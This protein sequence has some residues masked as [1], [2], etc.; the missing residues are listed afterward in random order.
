M[1]NPSPVSGTASSHSPSGSHENL[2]EQMP[3]AF[4][5]ADPAFALS[6]TLL[7]RLFRSVNRNLSLRLWNGTIVKVGLGVGQQ[8]SSTFELVFH[9]PLV[10]RSM[11][12]GRDPLRIAEAYFRGDMDIE[13]DFFAAVGLK[14]DLQSIRMSLY[15]RL[16]TLYGALQ[17]KALARG[18]PAP[19]VPP[20]TRLRAVTAHSK[21]ENRAAI[22]F[23]YDVSNDF[24][25]LWLDKNMVYS[26]AYFEALDI[27]LDQAQEAK[28][29]YVCRKLQLQPTDQLLDIGCGWGALII[30]AAKHYGVRA[31]GITL[32][33][34]QL[35]RGRE[36]IAEAGLENRV[37]IDLQDYRELEGTSVYEKISSVGMVEHV[38]LKNL[39]RYFSTVQRLLKPGGLFLN[40]G[41]TSDS[42]G[43]EK[44]LSTE[45][46]NRYVFPDGQLDTISNIQ[47]YM[48]QA[49]FEIADVESL[50]AHYALTLRHWVKRLE[51]NHTEALR[52]VN[53]FTYR[54]W[55][56]YMCAAAID[57]E[58]GQIGIYQILATKRGGTAT[59]T[60]MTRRHL[61][62]DRATVSATVSTGDL[63][64]VLVL[65][66]DVGSN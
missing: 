27:D 61:Y 10:V 23:H 16:R 8:P 46:I 65:D 31:R 40:H 62:S 28:L 59:A 1:N 19:A 30:H 22:K 15:D 14:D 64:Q 5:E 32:S 53:E 24:Y 54:V 9:G 17:L 35:K 47:R 25:A 37:T 56:L 7:T 2:R 60:R 50:R 45:F 34:E 41:I 66:R 55:R 63:G 44:T 49:R 57:F 51:R 33:L 42:G 38:G 3:V 39:P 43:W 13:G 6:S 29:E 11:I 12:L 52:F 18:R 21:E 4:V 36:R 58:S 48:E 20:R 26:C